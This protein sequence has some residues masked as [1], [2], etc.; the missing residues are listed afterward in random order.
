MIF[1]DWLAMVENQ[2]DRKLKCLQSDNEG[3]YKSDDFV[4]F[5]RERSIKREFMAPYS[6][7]QNGIAEQMN[8]TIQDARESAS[9]GFSDARLLALPEKS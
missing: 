8:R 9:C 1:K 3:E 4:Q 6:P 2:T 5:C 7:E